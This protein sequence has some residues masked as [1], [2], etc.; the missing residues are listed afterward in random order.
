[1]MPLLDYARFAIRMDASRGMA[2]REWE[3]HNPGADFEEFCAYWKTARHLENRAKSQV[4]LDIK[5]SEGD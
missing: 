2:Y 5:L 1:M 4:S 3:R